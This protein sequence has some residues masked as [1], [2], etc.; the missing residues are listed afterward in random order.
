MSASAS[1]TEPPPGQATLPDQL[2]PEAWRAIDPIRGEVVR[3]CW[4]TGRGFL[5]LTTLR[6]LLLWRRRELLRAKEW[7][8]SP[9]VMLYNVQPPRVLFG[10]FVEIAP[11]YDEGEAAIRAGVEDPY[12]VAEEVAAAIPDARRAWDQ[13]RAAAQAEFQAHRKRRDEIV[14]AIAAG[15]PPP[16]PRVPCRYCGNPMPITARRCPSCGAPAG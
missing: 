1:S 2:P 3:R 12:S 7:E 14:A 6:C 8:V 9:E 5:V 16:V 10:R 4:R 13:R 15:V 11:A